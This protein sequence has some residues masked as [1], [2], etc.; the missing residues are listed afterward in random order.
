VRPDFIEELNEF[1]KTLDTTKVDLPEFDPKLDTHEEGFSQRAW[2]RNKSQ[3]A[4][5]DQ[6]LVQYENRGRVEICDLYSKQKQLIHVKRLSCS[7]TLSHLFSQG[8][9]SAEL[10]R[11]EPRFRSEFLNRIPGFEWGSAADP[12]KPR[13][14]EI[15][16]A[17]ICRP[18]KP[19]EI[20]FFSKLSL[21][22]AAKSLTRMGFR[23]S[24]IGIPSK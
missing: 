24:W 5:L 7:A 9:V 12:I 1:L 17:I 6:K 19:L 14:F 15:S 23:V 22:S 10:F 13:E 16:Y 18:G 21:R 20:P 2:A 11:D 4:L 3:L 8:T